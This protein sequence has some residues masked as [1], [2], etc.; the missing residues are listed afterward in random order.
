MLFM[1]LL[2]FL[3][4]SPMM[5]LHP[6]STH[7]QANP[8]INTIICLCSCLLCLRF[9]IINRFFYWLISFDFFSWSDFWFNFFVLLMIF[10]RLIWHFLLTLFRFI[11]N[12]VIIFTRS[13]IL[14]LI[15]LVINLWWNLF[16]LFL[17]CNIIF[18]F[19]WLTI[20]FDLIIG[21]LASCFWYSIHRIL[22]LRFLLNFYTI[23]FFN[24]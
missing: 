18:F 24:R 5:P 7:H 8:I 2:I 19:I 10:L 14:L 17:F 1:M 3:F 11:R 15:F 23:L 20:I 9:F 22:I 4:I 21:I 16:R 6:L 12:L 13:F